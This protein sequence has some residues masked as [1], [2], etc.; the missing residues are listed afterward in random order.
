MYKTRRVF[1]SSD[2]V[3]YAKLLGTPENS[4]SYDI[5]AS[6]LASGCSK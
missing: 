4:D 3:C 6:I 5:E 1:P 2:E